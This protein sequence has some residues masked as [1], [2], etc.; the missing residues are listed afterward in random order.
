MITER[1]A[2]FEVPTQLIYDENALQLTDG[3][4]GESG[5]IILQQPADRLKLGPGSKKMTAIQIIS[6]MYRYARHIL[7]C[8]RN[9]TARASSADPPGH[10]VRPKASWADDEKRALQDPAAIRVWKRSSASGVPARRMVMADLLGVIGQ[11]IPAM[12]G[13]NLPGT[14][15]VPAWRPAAFAWIGPPESCP[16]GRAGR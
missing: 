16:R 14:G 13:A 7:W 9:G 3:S 12:M 10:S 5:E 15:A 6:M 2:V 1:T 11:P 4:P 8:P